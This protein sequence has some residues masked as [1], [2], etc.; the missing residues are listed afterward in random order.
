MYVYI[1]IYIYI[2]GA[3]ANHTLHPLL[4]LFFL[5]GQRGEWRDGKRHEVKR[6]DFLPVRMLGFS[7]C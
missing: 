4:P 3:R 2:Y 1:Y 7:L 5:G 6:Y